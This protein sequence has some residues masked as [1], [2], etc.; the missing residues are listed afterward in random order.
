MSK[1]EFYVP[2]V[3]YSGLNTDT[4]VSFGSTLAVTG[5]ATFSSTLAT[6]SAITSMSGSAVPA[7]GA[8]NVGIK[9]SSTANLGVFCGTGAPTV[10]A[11]KGSLYV[12]TDATTTTTRLYINTDGSTTWTTFTTAA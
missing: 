12:R 4:A 10:S 2:V 6:T 3:K 8:G 1:L 7:A 5:A 9:F 11:A